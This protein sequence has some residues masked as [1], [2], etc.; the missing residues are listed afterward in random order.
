MKHLPLLALCALVASPASAN[1]GDIDEQIEEAKAEIVYVAQPLTYQ[2]RIAAAEESCGLPLT[3]IVS[4]PETF[5]P[6]AE[7]QVACLAE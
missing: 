7:A 6:A 5:E 3:H 2:D 4:V 1:F